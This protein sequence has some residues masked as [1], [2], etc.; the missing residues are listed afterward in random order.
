MPYQAR[1][2][3]PT[4][5]E[6]I[7]SSATRFS[8][9]GPSAAD[10][11]S[12][13]AGTAAGLSDIATTTTTRLSAVLAGI[14]M[15]GNPVYVR[16]GARVSLTYYYVDYVF[17][18]I[19]TANAAVLTLPATAV[20]IT[21]TETRFTWDRVPGA[22]MY[23]FDV[24]TSLGGRQLYNASAPNAVVV[25]TGYALDGLPIY[26][27]LWT[28]KSGVW[29][30]AD[31]VFQRLHSVLQAV[32]TSPDPRGALTSSTTAFVW[33][34]LPAADD[35]WFEVGT[36]LGVADIYS[37][38]TTGVTANVSGIPITGSLVYVRLW[39]RVSLTWRYVDYAFRT[40]ETANA[41]VLTAPSPVSSVTDAS[42]RFAWNTVAG[43]EMY[44]LDVGTSPG[45]RDVYA[46]QGTNF[47]ATVTGYAR[48]GQPLYVRLWTLKAGVWRFVD[49]V[50]AR[51]DQV[52]QAVLSL[53]DRAATISSTSKTFT[54]NSIA[55]ASSYWLYLGSSLG[56]PN[57]FHRQ[58][59]GTS[60][61]VTGIQLNGQPLYVRM[62]TERAGAWTY[63]DY[64]FGRANT[65]TQATF[66]NINSGD[67]LTTTS[68]AFTWSAVAGV[69]SYW[70]DAGTSLGA[71][72]VYNQSAGT[73]TSA[74]INGIVLNSQPLYLRFWTQIAGAW[75]FVDYIFRR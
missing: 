45:G 7:T 14:P 39:S 32:L 41:A 71:R 48:N 37:A 54:W 25:L 17:Q 33:R 72:D 44:W 63:V 55:G 19:D 66:N 65:A 2:T 52:T 29:R 69:Q 67:T 21:A 38:E 18:T 11:Y 47:T 6:T 34:T 57:L 13:S 28:L 73:A 20:T 53:P 27:R 31:Y 16:L 8:W 22:E 50:F 40:A 64:V 42:T 23:W 1:L 68:F 49:Y 15:N 61:T 4:Q 3:L 70:L 12:I 51:A 58:L 36:G 59:T 10:Q 24:G 30:Y 75:S 5:V 62:W 60:L 9:T 56:A 46:A 35:Y 74:T 26:V 43:A